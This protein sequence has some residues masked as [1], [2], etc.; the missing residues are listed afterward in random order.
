M[1]KTIYLTIFIFLFGLSSSA[2]RYDS[3]DMEYFNYQLYIPNFYH[4]LPVS[5]E[6]GTEYVK[7]LETDTVTISSDKITKKGKLKTNSNYIVY[8]VNE[9]GQVIQFFQLDKKR[10]SSN[11]FEYYYDQ[12]TLVKRVAKDKDGKIISTEEKIY[13]PESGYSEQFFAINKKGDTTLATY[14]TALDGKTMTAKRDVLKKGKRYSQWKFDYRPDLSL[15]QA[16]FYRKGK[17]KYV[18]DYNCKK[19]GQEVHNQKDTGIQCMIQEVD[20]EGNR[21]VIFQKSDANGEFWKTIIRSNPYN[22]TIEEKTT[23]SPKD[24]NKYWNKYEYHQDDST[25]AKSINEYY[26]KNVLTRVTEKHF[27]TNGKMVF[28]EIRY[29]KKSKLDRQNTVT[30]INDEK[31]R[32]IKRIVQ[33]N[34]NNKQFVYRLYYGKA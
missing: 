33:N 24:L 20:K 19:E 13:Q 22:K 10:K 26:Q 7:N 28:N 12:N 31:G 5:H 6:D 25:L 8:L 1:Y 15:A 9:K 3:Y 16:S 23:Y 2:Q 14:Q 27:D 4:Y 21:L 32:P 17:L 34:Q 18:W 11:K 29:Y 30:F